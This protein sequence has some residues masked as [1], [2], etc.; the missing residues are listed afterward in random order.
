LPPKLFV[1]AAGQKCLSCLLLVRWG[2]VVC[3]P[4]GS[5]QVVVVVS[6]SVAVVG[7]EVEVGR[8]LV[9]VR[10]GPVLALSSEGQASG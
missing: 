6:V 4:V 5:W 8:F 3:W 2:L 7:V 9:R 10:S 1:F